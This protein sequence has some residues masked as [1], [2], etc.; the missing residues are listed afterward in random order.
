MAV[1]SVFW[2]RSVK[3]LMTVHSGS[4]VKKADAYHP[5][6]AMMMMTVLLDS[7]VMQGCVL[8]SHVAKIKIAFVASSVSMVVAFPL[9]NVSITPIVL[10]ASP[11]R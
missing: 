4:S 9:P 1:V 7:D 2:L 5:L 8:M 10:E 11:V 3:V 6:D